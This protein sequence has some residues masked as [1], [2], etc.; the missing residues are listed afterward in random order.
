VR[1]SPGPRR[2]GHEIRWDCERAGF[3]ARWTP[4]A[5]ACNRRLLDDPAGSVDWHC[6]APRTDAVVELNGTTGL[7]GR[8]Y[9][10]E[11]HLAIPPWRLPLDELRWGRF[12]SADDALTWIEWRGA[13]R[14]CWVI[15]NGGEVRDATIGT[16]RIWLED[17]RLG[18]ELRN[19]STLRE[20]FLA[21]TALRRLPV[22]RRWLLRG[23]ADAHET[24]WLARG[25]LS[26]P[27]RTS[28]G[29]AIHE[30]VRLR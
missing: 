1:S 4:T 19:E 28:S 27:T 22:V 14:R 30:L 11:L 7:R 13:E 10:E 25:T 26:T 8:G 17:E 12:H 2:S 15:H 9:V 18:I 21:E 6:H 16:D 3:R 23:I 20:G 24:K 29:W 5:A